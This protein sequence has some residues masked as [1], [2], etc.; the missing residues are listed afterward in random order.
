MSNIVKHLKF[1]IIY[2]QLIKKRKITF[3]G[4][5]YILFIMNRMFF[6]MRA[7]QNIKAY[8]KPINNYDL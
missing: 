4:S 8:D 6:I 3:D 1:Q 7:L 5:T 2:I